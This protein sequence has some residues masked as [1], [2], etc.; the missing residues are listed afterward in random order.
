MV[1]IEN[2]EKLKEFSVER[3]QICTIIVSR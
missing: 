3:I 1:E 2:E